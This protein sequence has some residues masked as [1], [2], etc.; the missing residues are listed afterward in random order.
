MGKK[1]YPSP[2]ISNN[3]QQYFSFYESALSKNKTGYIY[4]KAEVEHIEIFDTYLI[5]K[6]KALGTDEAGDHYGKIKVTNSFNGSATEISADS[7]GSYSS[8]EIRCPLAE[9]FNLRLSYTVEISTYQMYVDE[10]EA[11]R[12]YYYKKEPVTVTCTLRIDLSPYLSTKFHAAIN[13]STIDN[14]TAYIYDGA[15]KKIKEA[16]LA[17]LSGTLTKLK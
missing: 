9:K 13:S 8:Q 4:I 5:C 14:Y 3:G 1:V 6:I 16:H 15:F 10:K 11:K 7:F 17:N 12:N 2:K